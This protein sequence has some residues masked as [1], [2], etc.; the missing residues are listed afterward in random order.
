[1]MLSPGY[2]IYRLNLRDTTQFTGRVKQKL[3]DRVL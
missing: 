2:L 1:M 3:E